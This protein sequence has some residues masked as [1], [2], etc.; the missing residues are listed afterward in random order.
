MQKVA[1]VYN[2]YHRVWCCLAAAGGMPVAGTQLQGTQRQF[3]IFSIISLIINIISIVSV[4]SKTFYIQF[5]SPSPIF[6]LFPS[7]GGRVGV[8]RDHL[9]LGLLRPCSKP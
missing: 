5:V 4:I 8:N 1:P 3:C 9:P 2:Y 6:L 7:S